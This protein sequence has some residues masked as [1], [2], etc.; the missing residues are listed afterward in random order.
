MLL[1]DSIRTDPL[2]QTRVAAN[3]GAQRLGWWALEKG[4]SYYS[5]NIF[6]APTFDKVSDANIEMSILNARTKLETI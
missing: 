6:C 5:L 4:I 1:M 2:E 3:R